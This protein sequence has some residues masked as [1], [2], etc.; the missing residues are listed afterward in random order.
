MFM[1]VCIILIS[2]GG[3][4][5]VQSADCLRR[6]VAKKSRHSWKRLECVAYNTE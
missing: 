3:K 6:V 1:H 4:L 5:V 2:V